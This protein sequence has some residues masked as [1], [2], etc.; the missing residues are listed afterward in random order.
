MASAMSNSSEAIAAFGHQFT[1]LQVLWK[2]YQLVWFTLGSSFTFTMKS[3]PFGNCPF[4]RVIQKSSIGLHP[5]SSFFCR[6]LFVVC[7][8]SGSFVRISP[9]VQWYWVNCSSWKHQDCYVREYHSSTSVIYP[10]KLNHHH[11]HQFKTVF[12]V[13]LYLAS[14]EL[15]QKFSS[16][17]PKWLPN[18]A[19]FCFYGSYFCQLLSPHRPI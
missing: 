4:L 1:C 19:L 15:G 11:L 13:Y 8:L 6:I 16:Q 18:Y 9:Q 14:T 2:Y 7:E 10:V 5:F 17:L 3:C 12:W